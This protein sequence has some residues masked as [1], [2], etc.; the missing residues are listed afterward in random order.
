MGKRA[1]PPGA[2]LPNFIHRKIF[3]P[4]LTTA[5]GYCI[6]SFGHCATVT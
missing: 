6:M 1:V 2:A 3:L 4:P 5:A